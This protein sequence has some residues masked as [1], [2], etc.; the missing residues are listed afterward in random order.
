MEC[1]PA[2]RRQ[3]WALKCATGKDY[4]GENLSMA[5]ASKL[6]SEA[7]AAKGYAKQKKGTNILIAAYRERYKEIVAKVKETLVKDTLKCQSVVMNDTNYVKD[8]GKRYRF[9]GT[10]C[11]FVWMEYDKRS[12][13]RKEYDEF[14]SK[15]HRNVIQSVLNEL[16]ADLKREY[17]QTG[18]PLGAVLWQDCEAQLAYYWECAKI[19]K[20]KGHD[21]WV[22]YR[23]D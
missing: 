17:E 15:N 14:C 13:I 11:A 10:G 19:A 6:L 1:R 4:R 9:V 5:D 3:L 23:Y 21:V 20:E 22:N 18:C 2:S 12:K 7:N 16:P 8:D